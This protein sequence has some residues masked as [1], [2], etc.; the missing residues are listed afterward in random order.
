M[1]WSGILSILFILSRAAD[2]VSG[3]IEAVKPPKN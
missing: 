3:A 2:T 1:E